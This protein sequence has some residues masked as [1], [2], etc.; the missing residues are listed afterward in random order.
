[1]HMTEPFISFLFRTY[2][3]NWGTFTLNDFQ[4]YAVYYFCALTLQKIE[5]KTARACAQALVL[6]DSL[7]PHGL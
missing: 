2:L 5:N 6:F 7:W 1:M 4:H 3:G